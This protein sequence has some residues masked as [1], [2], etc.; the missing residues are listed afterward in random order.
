MEIKERGMNTL[1]TEYQVNEQ[2]MIVEA[3]NKFEVADVIQSIQEID[4]E[5]EK[6]VLKNR[7]GLF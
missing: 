6:L 7:P 1:E 2:G 4:K 5:I 3:M